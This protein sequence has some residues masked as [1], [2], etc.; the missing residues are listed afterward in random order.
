M[1]AA[2]E[3]GDAIV[4]P[5]VAD[6]V[7]SERQIEWAAAIRAKRLARLAREGNAGLDGH[8][9]LA[10]RDAVWWIDRRD[11]DDAALAAAAMPIVRAA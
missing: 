3:D 7:G 8:P 1:R 2:A 9:W 4:S 11:L 6:L 5:A 10:I